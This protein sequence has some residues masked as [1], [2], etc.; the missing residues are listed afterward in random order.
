MRVCRWAAMALLLGG[1][2]LAPGVA[3]AADMRWDQQMQ[4]R[5]GVTMWFT[6]SAEVREARRELRSGRAYEA[7]RLAETA[8]TRDLRHADRRGAL[9]VLCIGYVEIKAA[10]LA[11]PY[12]DDLV[13]L[14]PRRWHAFNSRANARFALGRFDKAVADYETALELAVKSEKPRGAGDDTES[15]P[16]W[17][18]GTS[19]LDAGEIRRPRALVQK[20]LE[21][22]RSMLESA[23][24]L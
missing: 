18:E 20:N 14:A 10:L 19:I 8:L 24:S 1:P 13:E 5:P 17:D 7:I 11:L 6:E 2:V 3:G 12:C 15:A 16:A 4:K 23:D 9:N 22:A 21:L